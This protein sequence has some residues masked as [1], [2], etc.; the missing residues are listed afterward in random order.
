M[1]QVFSRNFKAMICPVCK[2]TFSA[3]NGDLRRTCSRACSR[4]FDEIRRHSPEAAASMEIDTA[5]RMRAPRKS[6][7]MYGGPE[8]CLG[9]TAMWCTVEDCSFYKPRDD[10]SRAE[11]DD[12]RA[13]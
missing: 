8:T 11:I 3:Q 13:P 2:K 12:P 9:L 4:I 7:A 6:C 10:Q 5:G 1:T